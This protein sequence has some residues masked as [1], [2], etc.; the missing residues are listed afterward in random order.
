MSQAATSLSD[1]EFLIR[2]IKR[3]A[4]EARDDPAKFYGFVIKEEKTQKILKA[5]AHQKLLFDFVQYHPKSVLRMPT[6]TGKTLCMTAYS[7]WLLGKDSIQRGGIFSKT[8]AQAKKPL[9]TISDYITDPALNARVLQVFPR[10]IKSPKAG[11]PGYP[12]TTTQITVDRPPG[13][14]DSS[15]VAMG[16]GTS[17]S[18]ARLSWILTD[19]L[20]D[21]ENTSSETNRALVSSKFDSRLQTR[22][23]PDGGQVVMTNTP[24]HRKDKT[25]QLEEIGWPTLTM[26]IYGFIR[27]S[28][29]DAAWMWHALDT[30]LRPSTTRDDLRYDWYRLRAHDPDLEEE[31]PLF[32]ERFP[33][34]V[35]ERLRRDMLPYEFARMFLCEPLSEDTARCQRAWVEKC[36]FRGRDTTLES[37]YH[38]PNPTYMGLDLAFGQKRIHDKTV[39][40]T[41]ER[42]PDGSKRILD[43]ATG[44]FNG[45]EVIDLIA[46]RYR[47]YKCLV[48]VEGNQAQKYIKDFTTDKHD[49]IPIYTMATT[50]A[51][52]H[53]KDWGIE[54]IFNEMQKE[55]WIIPCEENG[56]CH[57]EVQNLI[58]D[59]LYYDPAKHTADRLMALW[60]AREASRKNRRGNANTARV[61]LRREMPHSGGF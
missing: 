8:E 28:N 57:K 48:M 29:A 5:V 50:Y 24:W 1:T 21:D 20:L 31:I 18:G 43:I 19:D 54:S 51:N 34:E 26:D 3:L 38:G 40:L 35:I 36:K 25:Y 39:A 46:E 53:H 14:R 4:A 37:H 13:L 23:E 17:V 10:L 15:L 41:I 52:K 61:G 33:L 55:E 32:P 2:G 12:W 6:G 22:L 11:Q 47:R 27:V 16:F 58:N 42:L 44:R 30:H 49:H 60:F 56:R 7:L 45:P 59:M 9:S